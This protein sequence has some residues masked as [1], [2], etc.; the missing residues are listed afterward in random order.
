MLST[1]RFMGIHA[2]H[3]PFG[4][5]GT[6]HGGVRSDF[7]CLQ[8]HLK[9]K[10]KNFAVLKFSFF[11]KNAPKC[12]KKYFCDSGHLGNLKPILM[13]IFSSFG[14]Q[15]KPAITFDHFWGVKWTF[16]IT[17]DFFYFL[18]YWRPNELKFGVKIG[19]QNLIWVSKWREK[20]MAIIWRF[21]SIII[22]KNLSWHQISA[23]LAFK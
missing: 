15:T 14:L 17:F 20:K 6:H 3:L 2:T 21:W 8:S 5:V 16:P 18:C 22:F 11:A 9:K 7:R 23:H 12:A 4:S 1:L 10:R 13:P 19:F